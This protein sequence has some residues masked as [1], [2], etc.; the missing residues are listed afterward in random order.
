MLP[1]PH[2]FDPGPLTK[3]RFPWAGWP[4]HDDDPPGSDELLDRRKEAIRTPDAPHDSHLKGSLVLRGGLFCPGMYKGRVRKGEHSDG[5]SQ[6]R[7]STPPGLEH[8]ELERWLHDLEWYPGKP[9]TRA[10]IHDP[11]RSTR[12]DSQEKETVEDELL[13]DEPGVGR[14]HEAMDSVPFNQK[15]Q[16]VD[17]LVALALRQVMT[18]DSCRFL[19]EQLDGRSVRRGRRPWPRSSGGGG[20]STIAAGSAGRSTRT[21][22]VRG[23]MADS[24]T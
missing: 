9:S 2:A 12:Q 17:Q 11:S 14:T 21:S 7:R 20:P 1:G 10:H 6:E 15:F 22:T 8:R 18:D 16:V 24:R 3:R 23:P 13:D 19:G 5:R 4:R